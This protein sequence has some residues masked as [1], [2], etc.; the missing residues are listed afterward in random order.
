MTKIHCMNCGGW[1]EEG[2]E[3]NMSQCPH[4]SPPLKNTDYWLECLKPTGIVLRYSV[5]S[6]M[7][8]VPR[9]NGVHAYGTT[10][11]ECLERLHTKL[12]RKVDSER[13]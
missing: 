3:D 5:G 9:K 12:K 8:H 2:E 10:P 7:A 1:W 4:C 13:G 6:W 11:T